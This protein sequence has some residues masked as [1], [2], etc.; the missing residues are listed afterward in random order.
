MSHYPRACILS[1]IFMIYN[2]QKLK[3]KPHKF[4]ILHGHTST[5]PY[6]T[7]MIMLSTY[8]CKLYVVYADSIIQRNIYIMMPHGNIWIYKW[9]CQ[10]AKQL[11]TGVNKKGSCLSGPNLTMV[12]QTLSCPWSLDTCQFQMLTGLTGETGSRW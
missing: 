8:R 1:R 7:K 12:N 3:Q 2:G 4:D 5:Y 9:I 6:Q 10:K 11:A